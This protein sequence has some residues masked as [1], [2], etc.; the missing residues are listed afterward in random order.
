M[1]PWKIVLITLFWVIFSSYIITLIGSPFYFKLGWFKG[2]YHGL[3]GWHTP[4]RDCSITHDEVNTHATCKY[5]K[6]HIMQD[7]QGNWF[8]P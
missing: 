4:D 3:M 6:N 2:F 1:E 8:I 7:S 5:C